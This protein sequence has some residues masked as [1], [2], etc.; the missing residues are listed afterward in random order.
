MFTSN[1]VCRF[2]LFY[3]LSLSANAEEGGLR[4]LDQLESTVDITKDLAVVGADDAP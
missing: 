4:V 3:F 1:T 2:V